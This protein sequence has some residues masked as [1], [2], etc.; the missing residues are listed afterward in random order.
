MK[1]KIGDTFVNELGDE[2]IHIIGYA[3]YPWYRVVYG[4]WDREDYEYHMV[5][6]MVM[7]SSLER[8]VK[9]EV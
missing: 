3:F 8:L 9:V 2:S 1:Y 5:E 6:V 7:E 4:F